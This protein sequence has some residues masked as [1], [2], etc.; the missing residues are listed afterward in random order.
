MIEFLRRLRVMLRGR[1]LDDDLAE[2]MAFH[3]EMEAEARRDAGANP[4]EA[5]AAARRQF[6][7]ALSLRDQSRDQWGWA[8]LET[9]VGDIRYG[10][11]IMWQQ[12]AVTAVA[13]LTLSLGI[14]ATTAVFSLIDAVVL[15]PLPYPQP[16]RL[17]MLWT[18]EGA[19]QRS[20]HVSYPDFDEWRTQSRSFEGMAAFHG[21]GFNVTGR[22]AAERI[23][24]IAATPD[25]LT[26]LGI[27]PAFGRSLAPT[28]DLQTAVISNRLWMTR[29]AGDPKALG[30]MVRLD[31]QDYRIVGVLP[32]TFHF[33]PRL[34]QEPDVLVPMK[35][36]ATREAF[37]LR[38]IGRLRPGVSLEAARTEMRHVGEAIV[39]AH[40]E[41]DPRQ[42]VSVVSMREVVVQRAST[43][44]L[45]LIGAVAFL[46]LIACVNVANLL[47]ARGAGR[48]QELAIR[49]AVGANRLRLVR[50]LLT[51]SV[52]MAGIGAIGG[53]AL[54]YV[55]LPALAA[56]APP[57]TPFFSRVQ[58]NGVN[59]NPSVLAFTAFASLVS[60]LLFGVVPALRTTRSVS[61]RARDSGV[62]RLSR[63]LIAVEMALAFVLLAGAGLTVNSLHRLLGMNPGF[64]AS[65]LLT[66]SVEL[67]ELTYASDPSRTAYAAR[68]LDV[69]GSMPGVESVTQVTALPLTGNFSTR[70]FRIGTDA[71]TDGQAQYQPVSPGYFHTL[72][73]TLLRGR[74]FRDGDQD[75][76]PLVAIVNRAFVARY[77]GGVE[78]L[79]TSLQL[80]RSVLKQG[81][82]GEQW[83][84]VPR[85]AEVVGVASDVSQLD[86]DA[87]ARPEIYLPYTQWPGSEISFVVRANDGA[88]SS[89]LVNQAVAALRGVDTDLP[90]TDVRTMD[91]WIRERTAPSR[92][93]LALL[94]LF[95]LLALVLAASGTFA[96][97]SH[98]VSRRRREIAVRMALGARAPSVV[99]MVL[100][101]HAAWVAVGV[102]CGVAGATAATRLLTDYLVGVTPVD[103]PTYT[104]VGVVLLL[105]A[106]AAN[107]WPAARAAAVPPGQV[108]KNE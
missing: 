35:P 52:L 87:A 82:A 78:P 60:A 41:L 39:R 98:A 83:T 29:Y 72:G 84:S 73:V 108:L 4:E 70:N 48:G 40:P 74:E 5:D 43:M 95:A 63:V 18:V 47:L 65:G 71:R 94:G 31:G 1:R 46:L 3:L 59:L 13:V 2:E 104:V 57:W 102:A 86:L 88:W 61:S 38:V 9:L 80:S 32:A 45:L 93:V 7:N 34:D 15:H 36:V 19:S 26:V 76:T 67:P 103:V 11:R 90:V 89:A 75:G 68:A 24:G 99:R 100:T 105:V 101:Q 21:A 27:H 49:V 107:V 58:D 96:V 17:A 30:E 33:Q 20:H 69:L 42:G 44:S 23:S 92:F 8:W 91:D 53:L 12:R 77:L 79:G 106:A 56:T 22:G 81:P 6:G 25:L 62:G 28:D 16:D 64:R 51:E 55:C 14:G 54:A 37:F 66:L 10:A 50:Q 85:M 97:V